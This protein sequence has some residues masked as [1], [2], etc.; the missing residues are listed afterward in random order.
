MNVFNSTHSVREVLGNGLVWYFLQVAAQALI[1]KLLVMAWDPEDNLNNP[2]DVEND[3]SPENGEE[4]MDLQVGLCV[5][6]LYWFVL[7]PRTSSRVLT[8]FTVMD[9]MDRAMKK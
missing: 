6:L 9:S 8:A 5:Y 1:N 7:I 2:S 4:M 3:E